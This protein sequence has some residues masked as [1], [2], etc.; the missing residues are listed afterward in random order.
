M[1]KLICKNAREGRRKKGRRRAFKVGDNSV[2]GGVHAVKTQ[3][4]KERRK[5]TLL[6]ENDCI[7]A[8]FVFD[9]F[10]Q[11]RLHLNSFYQG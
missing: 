4:D 8:D 1:T 2:E 10:G 11:R 6:L 7:L 5:L 9:P 3:G